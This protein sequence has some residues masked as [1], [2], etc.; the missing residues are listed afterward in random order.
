M[1]T[2]FSLLLPLAALVACSSKDATGPTYANIAGTYNG[3]LVGSTQGVVLQATFSITVTQNLGSLSGSYGL[4]GTL[5]DGVSVVAIQGV[6]SL[7]GTIAAG[8]N[9]SVNI[10]LRLAGC[11]NYRANFSGAY[12]N[13]N[14]KLT[15][16]GPVDIL[17]NS[18]AVVLSYPTTIILSR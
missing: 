5:N 9:P 17:N 2:R 3:V 16:S 13:T 14:L 18:C 12:D 11:P 1:C 8:N 7:T 10:T 6:G 15:I 4:T